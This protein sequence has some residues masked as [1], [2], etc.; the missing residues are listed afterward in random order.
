[1]SINA[2]YG[3]AGQATTES[4]GSYTTVSMNTATKLPPS[5]RETPQSVSVITRQRMDDQGMND[6][7]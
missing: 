6:L 2:D 1:L 5:I 3:I 4:S 7:N